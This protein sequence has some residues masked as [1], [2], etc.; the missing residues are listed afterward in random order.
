MSGAANISIAINACH[1]CT[2]LAIYSDTTGTDLDVAGVTRCVGIGSN[3]AAI[4]DRK[5]PCCTNINATGMTCAVGTGIAIN[6]SSFSLSI[7]GDTA[8]IYL[9]GAGVARCGGV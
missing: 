8:G 4:A 9:D 3:I 1:I 7:Y 2:S 5:I 6:A